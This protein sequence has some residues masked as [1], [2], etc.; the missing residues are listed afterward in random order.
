MPSDR[1]PAVGATIAGKYEIDDIIGRGG[2]GAVYRAKH[3]LTDRRVA[4]KWMLPDVTDPEQALARF[5]REAK[6]MGRI[7][8]PSVVGVL[9]VGVDDGAAFLVMELLRGASLRELLEAGRRMPHERAIALI[10]PALE[11]VAAAHRAGVV[12]R[13][14][15]PENLFVV[16]DG[17]GREVTTK[18]LDFGISKLR[19]DGTP[20]DGA[21]TRTGTTMGT[22]SYMSPEQVKGARDVDG[23]T[24]VWA[25]GTIVYEM[26]AGEVPFRG[27]TYGGLMVAIVTEDYVPL[28][29]RN[30]E[31]P[32]ALADAV[33][34]ALEK[35]LQRRWPD[36]ASFARALAE[37][38]PGV[39]YRPPA[40]AG[41]L[42]PPAGPARTPELET[43]EPE[44]V[45]RPS[46]DLTRN[47]RPREASS[48]GGSA[49]REVTPRLELA[50]QPERAP[51]PPNA[52]VPLSVPDL[53]VLGATPAWGARRVFGALAALSV[54]SVLAVATH[55]MLREAPAPPPVRASPPPIAPVTPPVA[56]VRPTPTDA[57]APSPSVEAIAVPL[58][59]TVVP[60]EPA[61]RAHTRRRPREATAPATTTAAPTT[62]TTPT[63][64]PPRGRTG[65]ISREEF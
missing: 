21:I 42:H 12:H 19:D 14:L 62:T 52:S 45:A 34:G 1:Q 59:P 38:A 49:P 61:P 58:S 11:G 32:T 30:Q 3:R 46:R 27:E 13:D 26:L 29:V 57:G 64:T 4:L 33:H 23:R 5:L 24:D 47:E 43:P 2:M 37:F 22:P 9:D 25:L 50:S 41:S 31:I 39:V 8:H 60:V 44:E 10:M 55:M 35:D 48:P 36:V 7:D 16:R 53:P 20:K 18:V 17:A 54:A 51:S 56:E 63:T 65:G 28:H 15:K 6:A 40:G